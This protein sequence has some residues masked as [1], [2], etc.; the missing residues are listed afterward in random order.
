MLSY[1][2]EIELHP[3]SLQGHADQGVTQVPEIVDQLL[4]ILTYLLV[5]SRLPVL[6]DLPPPHHVEHPLLLPGPHTAQGL[7]HRG[8]VD[9]GSRRTVA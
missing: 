8:S 5:I 9:Q 2:R 7:G 4:N 3:I 1:L 6:P